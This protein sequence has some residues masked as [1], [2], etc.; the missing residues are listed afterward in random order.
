MKRAI[1]V[2]IAGLLLFGLCACTM[3]SVGTEPTY[4]FQPGVTLNPDAFDKMTIEEM[5][6][7]IVSIENFL[8]DRRANELPE[9]QRSTIVGQLKELNLLLEQ[10]RAL[11]EAADPSP[12]P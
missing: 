5:E 6:E 3:L 10:E 4:L 9:N 7:M 11:Q 8:N 1:T 2:T 12:T